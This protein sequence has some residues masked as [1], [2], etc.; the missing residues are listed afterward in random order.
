MGHL[1]T[2]RPVKNKGS[3]GGAI[4][5]ATVVTKQGLLLVLCEELSECVGITVVV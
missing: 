3:C 4:S 1:G 2:C 5:T